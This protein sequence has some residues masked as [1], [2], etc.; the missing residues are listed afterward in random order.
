MYVE[1][2]FKSTI[3]VP[4]DYANKTICLLNDIF[5]SFDY[6]GESHMKF[7][8]IRNGKEV[9]EASTFL[10]FKGYYI[11]EILEPNIIEIRTNYI[12]Y[13]REKLKENNIMYFLISDEKSKT[14]IHE[15][16]Y[17]KVRKSR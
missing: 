4:N 13:M 10:I 8:C 5:E 16:K 11:S 7:D 14:F 17:D 3:I 12:K 1:T 2:Y 6:I 9:K 15:S